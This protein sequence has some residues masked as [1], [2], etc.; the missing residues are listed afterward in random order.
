MI[1][2]RKNGLRVEPYFE[3]KSDDLLSTERKKTFYLVYFPRN[4]WIF[5]RAGSLGTL[6]GCAGHV[7]CSRGCSEL[8]RKLSL[9]SAVVAYGESW[10]SDENSLKNGDFFLP[11][12]DPQTQWLTLNFVAFQDVLGESQGVFCSCSNISPSPPVPGAEAKVGREHPDSLV[13]LKPAPVRGWEVAF[14][15]F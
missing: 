7:L 14:G 9:I 3:I 13:A 6:T 11:K 10:L 2:I 4:R 5:S 1:N 15:S 12:K 8:G